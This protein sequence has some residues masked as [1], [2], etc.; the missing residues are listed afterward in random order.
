LRADRSTPAPK[1]KTPLA[2]ADNNQVERSSVFVWAGI[3]SLTVI[4]LV[5]AWLF[6]RALEG[7]AD[8][9]PAPVGAGELAT[10]APGDFSGYVAP[11]S[12]CPGADNLTAAASVQEQTEICLLNYAR[13]A[14]GLGPL[15]ISP[16]LMRS[17]EIKAD[18]IVRCNQFSH[19]ACGIDVRQSFAD[20]G[21]FASNSNS[22]FGENLAWGGAEAGSP[23]GALLG[24]LESPE[25]R[26]NLLRNDWQEQGIALVDVGDFRGVADSRIWVSH[27]GRRG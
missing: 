15:Q 27:F 2:G 26:A 8:T 19:E 21:Y 18:E 5:G 4:L 10:A 24:W 9:T 11:E 1:V 7:A 17:A 3:G 14:A 12:A 25:H 23:R 16:L 13:R 22:R 20:S 6:A